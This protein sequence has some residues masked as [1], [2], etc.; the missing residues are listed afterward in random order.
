MQSASDYGD[1]KMEEHTEIFKNGFNPKEDN[2]ED[3]AQELNEKPQGTAEA[4]TSCPVTLKRAALLY[5]LKQF[6]VYCLFPRDMVRCH[7]VT[8]K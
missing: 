7:V 6:P 8:K 4:S 2:C 1:E 3:C 5:P